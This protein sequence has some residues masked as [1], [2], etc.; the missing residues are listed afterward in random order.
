MF[1]RNNIY[2]EDSTMNQLVLI[3]QEHEVMARLTVGL[4]YK[5]G[6]EIHVYDKDN[7]IVIASHKLSYLV[8]VIGNTYTVELEPV[9][10]E[11]LF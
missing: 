3:N 8:S 5:K 9:S 1:G 10:D 2:K 7:T 11:D 4:V 6:D